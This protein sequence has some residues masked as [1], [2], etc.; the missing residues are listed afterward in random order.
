MD[1]KNVNFNGGNV[2]ERN[3]KSTQFFFLEIVKIEPTN[4]VQ[5]SF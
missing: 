4:R 1:F 3:S 2:A 5:S